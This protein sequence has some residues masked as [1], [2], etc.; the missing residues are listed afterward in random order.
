M[1]NKLINKI[2]FKI[3]KEKVLA[4]VRHGLTFVGG[5]LVTQGILDAEIY[6][7]LSGAVMTLVGGIWS[8][9]DKKVDS[10]K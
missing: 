9:L 1:I 7:E 3:M 8:I 4:I 5:V 6:L 10:E 2:I